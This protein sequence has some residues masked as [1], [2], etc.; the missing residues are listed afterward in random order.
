MISCWLLRG[1]CTYAVDT[2]YMYSVLDVCTGYCIN[3]CCVSY[4]WALEW[5]VSIPCF[6]DRQQIE[7]TE[8]EVARLKEVVKKKEENER[9]YQGGSGSSPSTLTLS[10]PSLIPSSPLPPCPC[11]PDPS[12]SSPYL[13]QTSPSHL[14]LCRVSSSAQYYRWATRQGTYSSQSKWQ[15]NTYTVSSEENLSL[16]RWS[17]SGLRFIRNHS[18]RA[19]TSSCTS[20]CTWD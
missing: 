5:Y 6:M 20:V 14:S 4:E 15:F 18:C 12:S 13:S 2:V 19:I 3:Q 1:T 9:K 16:L 8:R 7:D 10:F 11:S 17:R